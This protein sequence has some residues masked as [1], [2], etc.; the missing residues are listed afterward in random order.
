[1]RHVG[2]LVGSRDVTRIWFGGDRGSTKSTLR[3]EEISDRNL[4]LN[5]LIKQITVALKIEVTFNYA[6]YDMASSVRC[7]GGS[8]ST[9][10]EVDVCQSS[11]SIASRLTSPILALRVCGRCHTSR[12]S[13]IFLNNRFAKVM[14]QAAGEYIARQPLWLGHNTKRHVVA[15]LPSFRSM[16]GK[17][18]EQ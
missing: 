9:W 8:C 13:R 14:F 6:F 2:S 15:G 18:R 1:M 12:R 7:D 17:G 11:W 10:W 16:S 5:G 3:A 4:L